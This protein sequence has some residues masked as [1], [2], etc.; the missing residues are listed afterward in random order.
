MSDYYDDD[1]E[2]R[3]LVPVKDDGGEIVPQDDPQRPLPMTPAQARDSAVAAVTTTAYARAGEL[4]LTKEENDALEEFFPDSA[5]RKG[6]AGDDRLIYIQHAHLRDRLNKVIGRG[7]WAMVKR[8][9]WTKESRTSKGGVCITVFSEVMLVVRGCYVGEAVGAAAYYPDNAKTSEDDAIEGSKS[10]AFRRLAKDFGIGLQ[11]WDKGWTEGWWQRNPTGIPKQFQNSGVASTPANG[12][13]SP[14]KAIEGIDVLRA[15]NNLSD[16]AKKGQK[17]L[18]AAWEGLTKEQ[19][20]SMKDRLPGF[21]Q[22]AS[23]S[24][25]LVAGLGDA[26]ED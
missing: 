17:A 23:T 6:A 21:K 2:V 9:M 10:A 5:F 25:S 11:A 16:A 1:P 24:D 22:V 3:P 7:Q 18:K 20:Q 8:S 4:V 13:S 14:A 19:R 15:E 26:N 12:S